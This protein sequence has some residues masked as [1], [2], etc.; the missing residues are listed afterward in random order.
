MPVSKYTNSM[1]NPLLRELFYET[2]LSDKSQVLYTLKRE[3]HEGFPSLYQLYMASVLTDPMEYHFATTYL[4]GWSHWER[5]QESTWFK[6][7]LEKWRR[8]ADVRRSAQAL[9]NILTVSKSSSREA[10]AASRYLLEKG[11]VPKPTNQKG[12]PSKEEVNAEL[13]RQAEEDK[14]LQSDAERLGVRVQ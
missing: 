12:R 4:D 9:K 5:L 7:H 2:S 10:L 1:G 6:P 3:D 14:S 8:E 11:W 13:M